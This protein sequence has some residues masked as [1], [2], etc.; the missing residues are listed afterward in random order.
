MCIFIFRTH[1]MGE[2]NHN[3]CCFFFQI[4]SNLHDLHPFQLV[5]K[6]V[7]L[8][9]LVVRLPGRREV[10]GS[11]PWWCVTF[12]AE[13][14]PV[15]SRRLVSYASFSLSGTSNTTTL[16]AT[17]VTTTSYGSSSIPL[18][19]SETT[20]SFSN[21]TSLGY[22]SDSSSNQPFTTASS[23]FFDSHSAIDED[24][25]SLVSCR[26]TT[27]TISTSNAGMSKKYL[28]KSKKKRFLKKV[29]VRKKIVLDVTLVFSRCFM[30]WNATILVTLLVQSTGTD[31]NS[32]WKFY[33]ILWSQIESFGLVN[34]TKKVFPFSA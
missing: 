19:S 27:T 20:E 26:S 6:L 28:E 33:E 14:I 24:E 11:N 9:Q 32:S 12:L 5:L 4:L 16:S 8:A 13:I 22:I 3:L 25:K 1:I 2:E 34:W 30:K 21:I 31:Q 23:K 15:L 7:T 17:A 18:S 10:A 29:D